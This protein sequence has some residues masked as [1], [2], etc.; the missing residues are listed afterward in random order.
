MPSVLI[1]GAGINGAALAR[2]L[3]LNGLSVCVVDTA[4]MAAG[5]TAYSSRLIHGGLRY[6]EYGEFDLVRESLAERGRLLR[7]APHL[8]H[9]LRLVI[10]VATRWGGFRQSLAR[11]FRR[12]TKPGKPAASRGMWLVRTGLW[13][14]DRYANDRQLPKHSASRLADSWLPGL[15]EKRYHWVCAYSDAQIRFPERMVV[16][17]FE[18]ARQLAAE[19]GVKFQVLTYHQVR[20]EGTMAEVHRVATD[21][22]PGELIERFEPAVIVNATGAWVDRTLARLHISAK[23][24]MGGTKGSH[25]VT[26]NAKLRHKLEEGGLYAE[27]ADGRPVFVL[28]F[29]RET[30]IGTT[31]VPFS[32][33]PAEAVSSTAEIDYLLETVNSLFNDMELSRDDIDLHYSGVRPLPYTG[34]ATPASVTRRHWMEEHKDSPAPLYSIIGGKLTTCRSLAETSAMTILARLGMPHLQDSRQ[35]VIPGGENYP[36]DDAALQTRWRR[37]ADEWSWTVPQVRAVWELCG[38]RVE[39][40]LRELADRTPEN[41]PGTS[42]P[43]SFVRW[44]IRHEWATQLGDLVERRL[45]LLYDPHLSIAG[46]RRLAELLCDEGK[47][48]SGEIDRA[49]ETQVGRLRTHFGKRVE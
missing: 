46:L 18:D 23:P 2:E 24:L 25:L 16:A 14:Y 11:F 35:R 5:A 12:P 48:S 1:L 44:V 13:M 4:D 8:V 43:C 45:M 17:L 29:G 15:N 32:G 34:G 39:G 33:D 31:D 10:P 27:A 28:P 42:L 36:A 40:I 21:E 6:L 7:L 22:Q 38:T 37:L 19:K 47:L 9:P 41:L 49:V 26:S 20:L 3:V 30:L